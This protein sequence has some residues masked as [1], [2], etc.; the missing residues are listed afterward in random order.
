[1]IRGGTWYCSP[2]IVGQVLATM[3]SNKDQYKL[4]EPGWRRDLMRQA[5]AMHAGAGGSGEED[6]AGAPGVPRARRTVR[7]SRQPPDSSLLDDSGGHAY[8]CPE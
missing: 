1:M 3:L 2:G 6:E 4:L 5:A 7:A 8:L